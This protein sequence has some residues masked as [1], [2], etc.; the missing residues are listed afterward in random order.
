MYQGIIGAQGQVV[1]V[2][3]P[4]V[5]INE[6]MWMGDAQGTNH[7]WIELRNNTDDAID[8]SGWEL[9]RNDS[10]NEVSMLTIPGGSI[11]PACVVTL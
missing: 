1:I 9:T 8:I 6:I 7:E 2:V 3:L 10:G 4:P 5:V 11:I